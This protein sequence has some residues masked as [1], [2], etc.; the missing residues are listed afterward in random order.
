MAEF[1]EVHTTPK[2]V[3]NVKAT[4]ANLLLL[5]AGISPH[6]YWCVY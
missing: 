3:Y 4:S 5:R 1:E 2:K 6:A